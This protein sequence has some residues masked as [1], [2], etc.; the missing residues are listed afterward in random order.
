MRRLTQSQGFTLIELMVT[1]IVLCVLALI[2]YPT[3]DTYIQRARI[4]NTRAAMMNVIQLM[5]RHYAQNRTFCVMEEGKCKAPNITSVTNDGSLKYSIAFREVRPSSFVIEAEP[6]KGVYSESKLKNNPLYVFY[7]S[8]T[9]NFVR[10]NQTGFEGS[11]KK[12]DANKDP[13]I[14]CEVF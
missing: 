7:D 5:E 10:C 2:A 1:I 9:T 4:D 6:K 8:V 12:S 14:G 13:S 3:F 11:K